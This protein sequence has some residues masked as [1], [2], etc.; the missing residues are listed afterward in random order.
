MFVFLGL[1]FDFFVKNQV[2]LSV[3]FYIWVFDLIPL[4]HVAIAYFLKIYYYSSVLK[5]E[6]RD[7]AYIVRTTDLMN[8]EV[9]ILFSIV[10]AMLV[11]LFVFVFILI[12][13]SI[14]N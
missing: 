2:S 5:L 11:Y 7:G 4:M 1:G 9:R 6:V 8:L 10:L 13:F 3:L 14:G 12:C